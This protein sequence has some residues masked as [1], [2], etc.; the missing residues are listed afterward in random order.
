M[1]AIIDYGLGNL[2]SVQKAFAAVGADGRITQ[3]AGEI[4]SAEKIVLPGVGAMSSAM[5]K[6]NELR[7]LSVI[8]EQIETG[9]PFLGICLG[10]QLLFN[11]SE[12][13]GK[14]KGMGILDGCVRKFKGIKVPHIGWNNLK[15]KGNPDLLDGVADN[16]FVYFCHSYYCQPKDASLIAAQT[17]YGINFTSAVVKENLWAVQFHPEKSQQVGLGIVKNFVKA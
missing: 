6:L 1:I 16:A 9:K 13:G 11:E 10:M 8:K 17:D 5:Q 2:R 14:V 4:K 3:K 7:L 12:E 15:K